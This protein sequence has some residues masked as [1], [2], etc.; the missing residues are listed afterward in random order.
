LACGPAASVDVTVIKNVR[1]VS[2]LAIAATHDAALVTLS[3]SGDVGC[4]YDGCGVY[5][6][7]YA[8]TFD[9][10]GVAS[11]LTQPPAAAVGVSPSSDAVPFVMDGALHLFTQGHGGAAA[12]AGPGQDAPDTIY[13]VRDSKI[14]KRTT[15]WFSGYFAVASTNDGAIA[16]GTGEEW[17]WYKT[18]NDDAPRSARAFAIARD[19]TVTGELV[20]K[21]PHSLT[22]APG[23]RPAEMSAPAVAADGDRA[24]YAY[25][26]TKK[27]NGPKELVVGFVDTKTAKP[28]GAPVLVASGDI[29]KPAVLVQG[30]TLAVV[31][32]ARENANAPYV[33]RR[34]TLK[35]GE[36]AASA[37]SAIA[38]PTPTGLSPS[39]ATIGR[40]VAL[41]WMDAADT[42]HGAIWA[43]IGA[44]IDDAARAGEKRSSADVKNARD[45]RWGAA[46][47][48][49]ALSWTEHD[50]PRRVRLAWCAPR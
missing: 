13:V 35:S 22:G 29:G 17:A 7:A 28:I 37:P 16:L 39:L 20:D 34:A 9:A 6:E 15:K 23:D 36:T 8:L 33:L 32:A 41:A 46:G 25:Q 47:D 26:R 1:D 2:G 49:A 40:T 21:T 42:S 30:D 27:T 12:I 11:K 19:G 10:N 31:W 48:R 43:G 50:G 44:T 4:P 38:T 45:P 18:G 3:V 5:G 14:L 24:A